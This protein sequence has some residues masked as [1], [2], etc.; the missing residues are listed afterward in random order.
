MTKQYV[1][2]AVISELRPGSMKR[3]DVAGSRLLLANIDGRFCAVADTCPHEDASLSTGVLKGSLVRCPLH[4][5]RFDVCTGRVQEDPA[6]QDL[7]TY[8]V[9]IDGQTVQVAIS[10]DSTP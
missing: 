7:R 3:V 1:E 2:V 8:Q 9:R 4:G 6:E 5:S 10:P